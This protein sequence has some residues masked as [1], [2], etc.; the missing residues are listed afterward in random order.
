MKTKSRIAGGALCSLLAMLAVASSQTAT[1]EEPT[2]NTAEKAVMCSKC[3]TVWIQRMLPTGKNTFVYRQ[4]KSMI[5]PDCESAVAMFF[6]TG[7]LKHSCKTCG[8]AL[9]HCAVHEETA[10]QTEAP[11]ATADRAVMCAKCQTVWVRRAE[12]INK[13]TVYHNE[14]VMEC[15]DCRSA[16]LNFLTTGKWKHSCKTCGDNLS[17]CALCK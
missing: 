6:K 5:C 16:A 4:E 9:T 13:V 3:Q 8:D 15:P 1:S 11:A 17:A 2:T 12:H 14:Q 10:A 7:K